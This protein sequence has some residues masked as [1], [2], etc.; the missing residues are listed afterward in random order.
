MSSAKAFRAPRVAHNRPSPVH[1]RAYSVRCPWLCGGEGSRGRNCGPSIC[2]KLANASGTKQRVVL[3]SQGCC[4]SPGDS[5][6]GSCRH[7]RARMPT[8]THLLLIRAAG[9]AVL[10]IKGVDLI[11]EVLPQKQVLLCTPTLPK[12]IVRLPRPTVRRD[13]PH[14]ENM[15]VSPETHETDFTLHT[16]LFLA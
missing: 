7:A 10:N 4:T 14:I 16:Q 11:Y 12:D 15:L 5:T 6:K 2:P 9:H 3:P 1:F 8:H 13:G